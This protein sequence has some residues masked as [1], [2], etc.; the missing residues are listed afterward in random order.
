MCIDI[1]VPAATLKHMSQEK[2]MTLEELARMIAGGFDAVSERFNRMDE[3]FEQVDERFN[4][5]DERFNRVDERFDRVEL[6]ISSLGSDW[7]ERFDAL[8]M[9]VRKLEQ[10]SSRK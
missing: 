10:G 2:N 4:R 9:R 1:Y 3:R 8:E 7:R 6:H 5:V